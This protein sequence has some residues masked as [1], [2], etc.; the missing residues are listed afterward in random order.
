MKKM[1]Q[2]MKDR[3]WGRKMKIKRRRKR[4]EKYKEEEV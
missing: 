1:T 4:I 3:Q 2:M